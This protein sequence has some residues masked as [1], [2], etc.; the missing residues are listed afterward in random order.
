DP[1]P[2]ADHTIAKPENYDFWQ[3]YEP[4]MTPPWTGKLLAMTDVH[5]VTLTPRHNR[6]F[7]SETQWTDG[8]IGGA[9]FWRFRKVLEANHWDTQPRPHEVTCVNWPMI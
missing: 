8:R 7:D 5:P 9:S 6:I 1:A 4:Q 3:S 2:G